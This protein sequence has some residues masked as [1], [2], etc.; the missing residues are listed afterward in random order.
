MTDLGSNACVAAGAVPLDAAACGWVVGQ[1]P[2]VKPSVHWRHAS[3]P[4]GVHVDFG[5]VDIIALSQLG[6][7]TKHTMAMVFSNV[8]GFVRVNVLG[9]ALP[10]DQRLST[11]IGELDVGSHLTDFSCLASVWLCIRSGLGPWVCGTIA[12]S[13]PA[14]GA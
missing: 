12:V 14:R 3:C 4:Q 2:V 13:C 6:P 8:F 11:G 1:R 5:S 9:P 7:R 10:V